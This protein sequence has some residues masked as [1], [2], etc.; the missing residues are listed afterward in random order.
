MTLLRH[1]DNLGTARFIT[2]SCYRRI[3]LL[4]NETAIQLFLNHL[5][6]ARKHYEI[7]VFGYVIMP[8]HLHLVLYPTK[9]V[10]LGKVIGEIKSRSA[11][12]IF[13]EWQKIGLG[14]MSNLKIVANGKCGYKFWQ[15]RCYDHNCRTP[16]TV[17]EKIQY[18]HNN[19]VKRSLA[20]TPSDWKWS[21]YRWYAGLGNYPLEVDNCGMEVL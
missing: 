3:K 12:V 10:E 14:D 9:T 13:A 20:D 19:P 2:F 6:A 17:L 5:D 18:C 1:Y 15:K 16:E 7:K 8:E 11:R 21:S 4:E